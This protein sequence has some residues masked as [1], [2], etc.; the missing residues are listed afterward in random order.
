MTTPAAASATVG[1]VYRMDRVAIGTEKILSDLI[2]CMPFHLIV[3]VVCKHT[4]PRS[5]PNVQRILL[6][7]R[8][9]IRGMDIAIRQSK[10]RERRSTIR[11]S[12]FPVCDPLCG[13]HLSLCRGIHAA[14]VLFVVLSENRIICMIRF[15]E[16]MEKLL[17]VRL[18]TLGWKMG[19][20]FT[21]KSSGL[22]NGA[23]L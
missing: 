21:C 23:L 17:L 19:C 22:S 18:I 14:M 11:L 1:V 2:L 8:E 4:I 16:E 13:I 12:P 20:P 7:K 6:F 15:T 5:T 3:P 9:K 10:N